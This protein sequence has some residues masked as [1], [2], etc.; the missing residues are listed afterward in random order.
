[1]VTP[2]DLFIEPYIPFY[3]V[4]QFLKQI[5]FDGFASGKK[6]ITWQPMIPHRI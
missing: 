6:I 4:L 5:V 3:N 1:M 2:P